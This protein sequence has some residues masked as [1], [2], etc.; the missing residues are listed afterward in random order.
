M[1]A[2]PGGPADRSGQRA[3]RHSGGAAEGRSVAPAAGSRPRGGARGRHRTGRRRHRVRSRAPPPVRAGPTIRCPPPTDITPR[4][5]YPRPWLGGKWTLRD[6]VDYE[7]TATFALLE[8]AADNRETLLRQIYAVNR[9][10]I[11]AGKKGEI[12]GRRQDLRRPH[13]DRPASTTRT[14]PSTWW[15]SS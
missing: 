7:L 15:T 4:T 2:Q 12:G 8:A 9:N 3:H 5:E 14:R 6:I 10:T 1:V 13:S 11:E